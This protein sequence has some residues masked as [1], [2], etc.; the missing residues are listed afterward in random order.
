M[1][2]HIVTT[3]MSLLL[4]RSSPV[5]ALRRWTSPDRFPEII[6]SAEWWS[7]S[8]ARWTRSLS[9]RPS[10]SVASV[11]WLRSFSRASMS[12]AVL[13]SLRFSSRCCTLSQLS[14]RFCAFS[15]SV[16]LRSLSYDSCRL[17]LCALSPS[18]FVSDSL[19][20]LFSLP[21]DSRDSFVSDLTVSKNN[22]SHYRT[23]S[24]LATSVN[25]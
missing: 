10:A 3:E 16:W 25:N 23:W 2:K 20:L 19:C 12:A 8:A 24:C 6:S 21:L 18:L 1:H 9:P 14:S 5:S 11:R 7:R 4:P 22:Q 17:S 15:A 13:T